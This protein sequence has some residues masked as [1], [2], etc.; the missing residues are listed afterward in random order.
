MSEPA[1]CE[2]EPYN[3]TNSRDAEADG[4]RPDHPF[5]V[6]VDLSGANGE[7]GLDQVEYEEQAEEKRSGRFQNTANRHLR[8]HDQRG[9]TN[10]E[11]VG[12]EDTSCPSVQTGIR[13]RSPARN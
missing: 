12:Y 5:A 1:R 3:W 6:F 2:E 8:A 11:G 9:D 7:P 13:F 4:V 10:D